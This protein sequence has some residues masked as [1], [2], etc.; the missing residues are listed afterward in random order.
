VTTVP[1]DL[2]P[3][4]SFFAGVGL[5]GQGLRLW[6]TAPRLILMGILPALLVALVYAAGTLAVVLNADALGAAVTPFASGLPEPARTLIRAGGSLALLAAVGVIVVFTF[7]AVALA[8]GDP[9]Y[10]RIWRRVETRLGGGPADAEVGF[11]RG[12][13]DSLRVLLVAG[14]LGLLLVLGGFV[15]VAGQTLVPVLGVLVGGWFLALELTTWA[16]ESRGVRLAERR[17][18]LRRNRALVLGFGCGTYL[19]FL[20]PFAAVVLMPTAV[21][22]ATLLARAVLDAPAPGAPAPAPGDDEGRRP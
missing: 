20:V 15:P 7:T 3:V 13:G 21:A 6:I 14:G 17:R 16:F 1:R 22:G 19:L 2:S 12:L 9:F 4:Q 8:V 11:W 10:E 5:I 18:M